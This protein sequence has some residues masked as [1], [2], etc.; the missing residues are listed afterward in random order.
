MCEHSTLNVAALERLHKAPLKDRTIPFTVQLV[1]NEWS[2]ASEGISAKEV[3]E[4]K[5]AVMFKTKRYP[6]LQSFKSA[7][8][9]DKR[10]LLLV[11]G[12]YV[13]FL[14]F[15]CASI[16][17]VHKLAMDFLSFQNCRASYF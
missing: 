3:P 6:K 11:G 2:N 15:M 12:R 14:I 16:M 1:E 10:Y 7:Y 9:S 17:H 8:S 4:D 5:I 13:S